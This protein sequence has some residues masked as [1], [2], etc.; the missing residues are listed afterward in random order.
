M[1]RLNETGFN[2]LSYSIKY[3]LSAANGLSAKSESF[4]ITSFG[5]KNI[6]FKIYV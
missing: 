3:F 5:M 1:K 2:Q 6:S 4:A